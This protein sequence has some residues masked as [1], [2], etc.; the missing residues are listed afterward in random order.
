MSELFQN[1]VALMGPTKYFYVGCTNGDA[2]KYSK[3]NCSI[4][5]ALNS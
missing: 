2:L 4:V 5:E 3:M 1:D